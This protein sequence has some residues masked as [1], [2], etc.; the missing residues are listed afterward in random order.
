MCPHKKRR[1]NGTD[2]IDSNLLLHSI[3]YI[4]IKQYE[5]NSSKL[6]TTFQAPSLRICESP[7]ISNALDGTEDE[8][9][10]AGDNKEES[11]SESGGNNE[12]IFLD[13]ATAEKLRIMFNNDEEDDDEIP[14]LGF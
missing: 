2:I 13:G 7:R 11:E 10:W 4:S 1:S 6:R 14:F 9:L 3:L 8:A 12:D 5:D